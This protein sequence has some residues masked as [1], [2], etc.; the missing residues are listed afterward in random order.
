M[1]VAKS[2]SPAPEARVAPPAALREEVLAQPA[3]LGVAASPR[4]ASQRRQ[5]KRLFG[6][7]VQ[8][9]VQVGATLHEKND[10]KL[11]QALVKAVQAQ[12][13][14]WAQRS[15]VKD[16]GVLKAIHALKGKALEAAIGKLLADVYDEGR[17]FADFDDLRRQCEQDLA[18]GALGLPA[19]QGTEQQLDQYLQP[20]AKA[21]RGVGADKKGFRIYR[22]MKREYWQ[23]YEKS[24]QVKDILH[25]HGGALGQ[26]LDYFRKSVEDKKLDDVLVEFRF[27]EQSESQLVDPDEIEK[28]GEGR[29]SKGGKMGGK[30][31]QNDAIGKLGDIYS[32]NLKAN[33]E[34]ITKLKPEVKAMAFSRD[35]QPGK[36]Q[37]DRAK[38]GP[39]AST[40][41][42]T[43]IDVMVRLKRATQ[44]ALYIL[45]HEDWVAYAQFKDEH[46]DLSYADDQ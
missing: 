20:G 42:L 39:A 25:G 36:E 46:P 6:G 30:S 34:L 43:P 22:C 40:G 5:M 3:A 37:A 26:A 29:G 15:G 38:R 13:S 45:N 18:L 12:F 11:I 32:I 44:G 2:V 10:A 23:A 41:P 27:P 21:K 28:G 4:L 17:P 16:E 14:T 9:K 35:E 1:P 7:L 8:L 33:A 24:G 31:E 19:L